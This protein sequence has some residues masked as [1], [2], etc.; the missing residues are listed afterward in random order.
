MKCA[1]PSFKIQEGSEKEVY[2][3]NLKFLMVF[4]LT[5]AMMVGTASFAWGSEFAGGSGTESDPYIIET[6]DQLNNVRNHLSA[7]FK[8][9]NDITLTKWQDG[10]GWEPIDNFKGSF[11]GNN[12]VIKNLYINQPD[13][14]YVGFFGSLRGTVENLGLE[15]VDITGRAGVGALA[16]NI[17]SFKTITKCYSTG[18]VNGN[19][20]N[21]GGLIGNASRNSIE[22]SYSTCNVSGASTVGGLIGYAYDA[23]VNQS[24]STGI[25]EGDE[26]RVGGLIGFARMETSLN[27]CFSTADVSGSD[28]VGGLVGQASGD[29]YDRVS[30]NRS[31]AAGYVDSNGSDVGGL[32]GDYT[33]TSISNN[34]FDAMTTGQTDGRGDRAQKSTYGMQFQTGYT[35]WNF[36][37]IWAIDEGNSYPYLKAF[38]QAPESVYVDSTGVYASGSGTEND[39]FII[40]TEDQLNNVR[41]DLSS[42]FKLAND[43]TLTKWQDGEGWKPIDN[44][45]GSFNGNNHVIK[46]LYINQPDDSYVGFFGSLRGTVENLG[47]EDVDITGRA[48]VGALAGNIYSFKTITKCYSTGSVNGNSSNIGGLIGNASRNSIEDSYS[49]CNVSGASTVGGLI[50]YAYDARVNQSYSTG[51]VEG[52]ETRVGGLI[53]FARMET[54]LNDCFSTADVSGSDVVGGLVGQASGDTYDRVSINRSYAAGYVDSNGSDVGGLFGDYTNTSISNNYFDAMTTGQTDGRGDRAPKTTTEMMQQSTFNNWN[55]TNI[56]GINESTSYP[57]LQTFGNVEQPIEVIVIEPDTIDIM[58]GETKQLTVTDNNGNDITSESSYTSDNESVATVDENGLVTAVGVGETEITVSYEDIT[59][60]VSVTVEAENGQPLLAITGSVDD[61]VK[62]WDVETGQV[63]TNFT[64]HSDT[65]QEVAFSPDGTKAITGS[66]DKTA[67]VWDVE[68]GQ[69]IT[70][71]TGHSGLVSTSAFSPD[72]T[73][74]ITGS[75]DG[76]AKVWDVETGQVITN[77]TEHS[78][79]IFAAA[80]S[81]DGTKAITGSLDSIAKVWDVETGEVITNFTGHSKAISAV[82]FSPEGTKAITGSGDKTAKIW[83]VE[84]GEVITD[85][86]GHYDWVNAVAF[87]PDGTKAITGSSDK[88]AKVWDVE[89]GQVITNFTGHSSMVNAAAFSPDGTKAITGSYD[90]T[91]KVWD[92]ETGQ[93]ITNFTGHSDIVL[94]AAFSPTGATD[95]VDITSISVE[96]TEVDLL[97]DETAQLTVTDNNDNDITSESSYTSD[98]QSVAMVDE[99]GL[100]TAVGAGESTITAEYD[101][102]TVTATVTVFE[103]ANEVLPEGDI[104]VLRVPQLLETVTYNCA[105]GFTVTENGIDVPVTKVEVKDGTEWP[106]SEVWLHLDHQITMGSDVVVDF[107]PND[108][109]PIT[110]VEGD[111]LDI[112]TGVEENNS[113]TPL[114]VE[115]S[116]VVVGDSGDV[117]HIDLPTVI[118]HIDYDGSAGFE[119]ISGGTTIP[120]NRVVTDGNG[121]GLDLHLDYPVPSGETIN[122]G[123]TPNPDYEIITGG[124]TP[125]TEIGSGGGS[126]TIVVDENNS[127]APVVVGETPVV[128]EDGRT[129]TIITPSDMNETHYEGNAGFRVFDQGTEIPIVSVDVEGN[130]IIL[131]LGAPLFGDPVIDYNPDEDYPIENEN[132]NPLDD[133]DGIEGENPSTIAIDS[134]TVE[135]D[136]VNIDQDETAQM[137]VTANYSDGTSANVTGLVECTSGEE[138]TATVSNDGLVTG[139]SPG[140]TMLTLSY[141]EESVEV[142]VTVNDPEPVLT[143]ITVTPTEVNVTAG[144][145]EQLTVVANYSDGSSQ[146]VTNESNYNPDNDSIATTDENTVT[147]V[148]EGTTSVEVTYEGQSVNV[149][150]NVSAPVVESI[151]VTPTEVN[152]TAG[153]SEQLTVVA[154]YSDGTTEDVTEQSSYTSDD[155][156]IANVNNGLVNRINEGNTNITVEFN[157]QS[158]DVPVNIIAPVLESISAEDVSVSKAE[159]VQLEVTAHYSDGST[160]SITDE[161]N[162]NSN[163]S[164]TASVSENGLITGENQGN[165]TISIEYDGKN[166]EAEVTVTDPNVAGLTVT[167]KNV[168]LD[169]G[170]EQQLT[171]IVSYGDGTTEDV[172]EEAEYEN[173]WSFPV[174]INDTGLITTK[175]AGEK[176]IRV[177]YEGFNDIVHVKVNQEPQITSITVA[178][179]SVELEL[180]ETQQLTVT[181]NYDDGATVDITNEAEYE[182]HWSFPVIIDDAG[183]ITTKQAGEADVKVK[184]EGFND[185]VHVKVNAEPQIESIDVEP[186]SV[187]LDPG[188]TQ[189]LTVTANYDDG[190]N[191]NVTDETNYENH[192]SYPVNID[193]TGLVSTKQAGE[194]DVKVK[195]QG[196]TDTVHVKV[197]SEP[198]VT[199]LTVEPNSVELNPGDTEQLTVIANYSDGSTVEVTEEASYDNYWNHPV[200][201]SNTGLVTTLNSGEVDFEISYDGVNVTVPIKVLPEPEITGIT[202]EPGLVE[203][204][205]GEVQQ[206]TVTANYSDDTTEDV[207]NKA[208]YDTYWA[209]PVLVDGNGLMTTQHA[210]Q[211]GLEVSYKGFT[212]TITVKVSETTSSVDGLV[213]TPSPINLE[214][215]E[216][217]QLKAVIHYDDGTSEDVTEK[218]IYNTRWFSPIHV[219]NEGIITGISTG[220]WNLEAKYKDATCIVPVTID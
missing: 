202:V 184:Y 72:G 58:T 25:V 148:G 74:A 98:N 15:D 91:A 213:I 12:H 45:E 18:S 145:S 108:D 178:P 76:T 161:A 191:V 206:L 68:T 16:G 60:T 199:H 38:S 196:F 154:N 41:Y 134:F 146:E 210:G 94:A 51:I 218:V 67:K 182:N 123:Y 129:V 209:T 176:D 80:F 85:F 50:G 215:G 83:G 137:T 152:V 175:Q 177:E 11:N 27:D 147:G 28:V 86:T 88:T 142:S 47:L 125:L 57:Y 111:E 3:R 102:L 197:N 120:V 29:T 6:E 110:P 195:Y 207:T 153:E 208:D 151:T 90:D 149:Q 139:V 10:E 186:N 180:D 179:D 43:I 13:D 70:N 156:G 81:P 166:T 167:P 93:V 31:Y 79:T 37:N 220:T 26:T 172:T 65:I 194:A 107:N 24:Y 157:G 73:K 33:N 135:P 143:D 174:N 99:N 19:S 173:H 126:S 204:E 92:V 55:F 105:A 212:D 44:F 214:V 144:K 104:I 170:E 189:Q 53:G 56:W 97:V 62:V 140:S 132:G 87:S 101:D 219:S 1:A 7:H 106:F 95:P 116:T 96:P 198:E 217:K 77:F 131:T 115:R 64:K 21:I 158:V 117:V 14:S 185:T 200:H 82:A 36:T 188:D 122:I 23:R 113:E 75:T 164:N 46:N 5:L 49:T 136:P 39:P 34:Y 187:E 4:I 138:D 150:V 42:H 124:G 109:C 17:Y 171:A 130:K 69:V 52:D 201:V 89:T 163:D 165:T 84:T 168:T 35:N 59:E 203:L 211:M 54:S 141:E 118:E 155:S 160:V 205:M 127:T 193:V 8:L 181:A 20:S 216:S 40:E 133:L 32:F 121:T 114:T 190:S 159:T 71:F 103:L 30:I 78:D 112:T 2:T 22:D 100:V 9:A 48:G 192:W 61:T 169:M 128:F 63:I 66:N 162:Y 119:I 183:L